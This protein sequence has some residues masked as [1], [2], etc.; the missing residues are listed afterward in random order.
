MPIRSV[1]LGV[2][3]RACLPDDYTVFINLKPQPLHSRSFTCIEHANLQITLSTE[4]WHKPAKCG[5]LK[6]DMSFADTTNRR[7]AGHHTDR[8]KIQN[9][10]QSLGT[11]GCSCISCF[12]TSM[13]STNDYDFKIRLLLSIFIFERD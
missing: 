6:N 12:Y 9:E 4:F 8:I 3:S 1:T 13:A 2:C 5:N 10:N 7:V 11:H